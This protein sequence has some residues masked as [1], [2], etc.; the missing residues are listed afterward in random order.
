MDRMGWNAMRWRDGGMLDKGFQ[1]ARMFDD[2]TSIVMGNPGGWTGSNET[3]THTHARAGAFSHVTLY[4]T[5]G[6]HPPPPIMPRK[7]H[8]Q[9]DVVRGPGYR[10]YGH[11]VGKG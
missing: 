1:N 3:H 9:R 2:V 8:C 6:F 7:H 11:D 5:S 10:S 4:L